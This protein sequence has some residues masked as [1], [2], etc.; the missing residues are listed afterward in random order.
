M[1]PLDFM[2][3]PVAQALKSGID[4][5]M[6][7]SADRLGKDPEGFRNPYRSGNE[8]HEG[9]P[10]SRLRHKKAENYRPFTRREAKGV[11]PSRAGIMKDDRPF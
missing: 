11:F 6:L 1:G 5:V 8:T 9:A 7:V 10:S 2:E 3:P 4:A